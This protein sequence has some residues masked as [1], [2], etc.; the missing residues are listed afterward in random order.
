MSY[1]ATR[2]KL[3]RRRDAHISMLHLWWARRP[4]AAARAAIYATLVPAT[5]KGHDSDELRQRFTDLCR[6]VGPQTDPVTRARFTEVLAQA[7]REILAA[8]GGQRPKVLDCFAGGGAIPLEMLR[9]GCE[10]YALDLNPVAHL[11][12]LCC[13]VYPQRFGAD[14]AKDVAQ[15]GRWMVEHAYEELKDLYPLIP[16][17]TASTQQNQDPLAN[18]G[19]KVQQ[20]AKQVR[21]TAEGEEELSSEEDEEEDSI[22]PLV[23][24]PPGYL[25]PVAYLWTRTVSCP[26]PSCGADVPLLRQTWLVKK[27]KRKAAIRAVA[28]QDQ[29]RMNYQIVEVTGNQQL[30]FDPSLGSERGNASCPFCGASVPAKHIQEQAS[31]GKMREQPMAWVCIKPGTRGK[32]YLSA[33]S[34]AILALHNS[35][36]TQRLNTLAADMGI[37]M[38]PEL[39]NDQDTRWFSPPEYGLLHFRDLFTLRQGIML[40]TFVKWIH[41]AHT[42]M[43]AQGKAT[44]RAKAITTYL[45]MTLDRVVDR[46]ST[47]CHWDNSAEKTANTYS[48]QALP[49]VWDFA[50]VNPFS[51]S[52]GDVS[53]AVRAICQVIEHCAQSIQ[54]LPEDTAFTSKEFSANLYRGSASQLPLPPNSLDAIITDPPYYDNISYADLSD[55]FYVWLKRSIGFLYPEHFATELTPKKNEAVAAAYRH[56]RNKAA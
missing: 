53:A 21:F 12:E 38:P 55:F 15:W 27:A 52:S 16:D 39:I 28:D 14:L 36:L 5:A 26:N 24:V 49:M 9:L 41:N 56:E 35:D 19:A 30:D 7:R 29:Q 51:G 2:E 23:D 3:L 42:E 18:N 1:E 11:I 13:L 44:D 17:P 32:R 33:N 8:N 31:A 46:S 45:G 43:V 22:Q 54:G 4:L 40:L 20:R 25:L 48:R 47:L 34:P 6:W 37:A 50:E 10:T